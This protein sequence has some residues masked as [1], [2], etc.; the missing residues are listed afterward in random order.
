MSNLDGPLR[1]FLESALIVKSNYR[2]EYKI[3]NEEIDS[4]QSN[5][6]FDDRIEYELKHILVNEMIKNKG[7]SISKDRDYLFTKYSADIM[8]FDKK[9]FREVLEAY[10]YLTPMEKI[11]EIKGTKPE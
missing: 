3:A 6:N 11:N 7:I 5:I 4:L 2:A 10:I 9:L 1:K 8:M